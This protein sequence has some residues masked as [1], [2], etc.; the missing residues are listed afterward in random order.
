[1][2]ARFASVIN[3]PLFFPRIQ[4]RR[5]HKCTL[6]VSIAFGEATLDGHFHLD[7]WVWIVADNFEVLEC[8]VVD[9]ADLSLEFQLWEWTRL[10]L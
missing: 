3:E 2:N 8:E 1:M 7:C 9:V 10:A 5:I 4:K 6:N